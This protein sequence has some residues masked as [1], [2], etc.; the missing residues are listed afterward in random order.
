MRLGSVI[1]F[2]LT[3]FLLAGVV[4]SAHAEDDIAP[5]ACVSWQATQEDIA[6]YAAKRGDAIVELNA[7]ESKAFLDALNSIGEHTDI[8]A[9][10]VFFAVS[11]SSMSAFMFMERGGCVDA[12]QLQIPAELFVYLYKKAKGAPA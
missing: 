7:V 3:T 2:L 5:E 4:Y 8:Q 10:R 6:P 11:N 9:D 1:I 12:H